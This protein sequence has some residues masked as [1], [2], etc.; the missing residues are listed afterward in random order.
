MDYYNFGAGP[1]VLPKEVLEKIKADIPNWKPGLSVMEVSHRSKDFLEIVDNSEKLLRELLNIPKNYKIIFPTGGARAQFSMVPI[2]LLGKN[3]KADYALTG[4]WSALAYEDASRFCT[5]S[6]AVNSDVCDYM[7]IPD[8]KTWVLDKDAAFFHYTDNE[9]VNGL[10]FFDVPKTDKVPLVVDMTSN[11]LSKP[12]D[13]SKYGLIYAS[14]QKNLGIAG[15]TVVIYHEDIIKATP[16]KTPPLYDYTLF[17][18]KKSILNTPPVFSWYVLNL[19]LEWVKQQGGVDV[20]QKN[21]INRSDKLYKYIDDSSFYS[22][23]VDTRYRSKMNIPFQLQDSKLEDKF[24]NFAKEKG[25]LQIGGHRTVGGMRAS[26]YN[27]MPE[28]GIDKLISVMDDFANQN[29]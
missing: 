1:G 14:A 10:E 4:L 22:N 7:S 28:A 12:I 25:I 3:T 20:M 15:I 19:V 11:I 16:E 24:K 21:S 9:T 2:N 18:E 23:S 29:S 13:V 6:I 8:P 5:N 26:M 17:A 27:A